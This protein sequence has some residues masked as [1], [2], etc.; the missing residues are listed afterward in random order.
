MSLS[1]SEDFEVL[2]PALKIQV[3]KAFDAALRSRLSTG[4]S[5]KVRRERTTAAISESAGGFVIESDDSPGDFI[6]ESDD[7]PGDYIAASK[8]N[9]LQPLD[10]DL[11][12]LS[13][14]PA[15]LQFLDLPPDDEEVLQVFRNAAGGWGGVT[16][17]HEAF[18]TPDED[19]GGTVTRKDWRA[20]CAVILGDREDK[21]GMGRFLVDEEQLAGMQE[22]LSDE[23][24]IEDEENDGDEDQDEAY[25]ESS[26]S[27][28]S[29]GHDSDP[30]YE[31]Y[32][33]G[34]SS[35]K[36]KSKS[37]RR[38]LKRTTASISRDTPTSRQKRASLDAFA[39]FFPSSPPLTDADLAMKQL[40]FKDIVR[41]ASLLKEKI[42]AEEIEEM[43]S[44]YSS[45]PDK[46]VSLEDF[47][48][49]LIVAK[50]VWDVSIRAFR[51]T[52]TRYQQSS[53]T[54]EKRIVSGTR[55]SMMPWRSLTSTH[56][57]GHQFK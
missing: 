43:L 23:A 49:M 36:S 10:D 21:D 45:S 32:T 44:L 12:Q 31:E 54:F 16:R 47:T 19:E 4:S 7:P 18:P 46:S 6:I 35:S 38:N 1:E 9:N 51:S 57:P 22:G 37:N 34:A 40:M 55:L 2:S 56:V 28:L 33:G 27:S 42:T 53:D 39:L 41:V 26:L 30:E 11:I 14:I 5:R 17:T 25:E 15:A 24:E 48:R 13:L 8:G 3:D 20:V 29:S 52:V 50:L